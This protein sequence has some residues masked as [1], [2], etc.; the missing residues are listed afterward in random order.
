M[1]FP[2]V[3]QVLSIL[4]MT[5]ALVWAVACAPKSSVE[6]QQNQMTGGQDGG[7]GH[8]LQ[9]TEAEVNAA[10]DRAL[11]LAQ[12]H[13]YKLNIFSMWQWNRLFFVHPKSTDASLEIFN[14]GCR[15]L[16]GPAAEAEC[17]VFTGRPKDDPKFGTGIKNVRR[18]MT[19]GYFAATLAKS[20]VRRVQGDCGTAKDKHAHASVSKFEIGAEIC[21]SLD[22]LRRLPP[23]ALL[24]EVLGLLFHEMAH[25]NGF[26]ENEAHLL[27]S[28]FGEFYIRRFSAI[29]RERY[30]TE[31]NNYITEIYI[32]SDMIKPETLNYRMSR[33]LSAIESMPFLTD[34]VG[35]QQTV[36]LES[37]QPAL[38]L[39][40]SMMNFYIKYWDLQA[41]GLPKTKK[42]IVKLS[43][44]IKEDV[45]QIIANFNSF[46]GERGYQERTST[47]KGPDEESEVHYTEWPDAKCPVKTDLSRFD[48][49]TSV[50]R[51]RFRIY[52]GHHI[53][54]LLTT[55]FQR[56]PDCD[57]SQ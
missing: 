6:G 35:I 31:M 22:H 55:E 56:L 25:L 50:D 45:R 38:A 37:I 47:Y 2:R 49:N 48:I 32:S 13:D 3:S 18:H 24:R 14:T 41:A 10:I 7:G 23:S 54:W 44:E 30:F 33:I 15:V 28:A 11:K 39:S 20:Q 27:Q 42:E 26:Q 17:R 52:W 46:A 36:E 9:S 19:K 51:L 34:P 4:L 12:E 53:A 21:L 5:S 8:T 16:G 57:L 40:Y 43:N 1:P 29:S